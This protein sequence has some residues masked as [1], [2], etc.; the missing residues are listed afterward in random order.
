M[1]VIG[2]NIIDTKL[3]GSVL[4]ASFL[5]KYNL[6]N[7]PNF[8][9]IMRIAPCM[10]SQFGTLLL[11]SS[12]CYD[13]HPIANFLPFDHYN[14]INTFG[15]HLQENTSYLCYFSVIRAVIRSTISAG[16]AWEIFR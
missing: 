11:V 10:L 2:Y 3:F 12:K 15:S 1:V 13:Y 8:T 6:H 9:K 7:M 5:P 4:M 14:I 16:Q